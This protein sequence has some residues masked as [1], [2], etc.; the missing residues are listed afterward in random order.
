MLSVDSD[1]SARRNDTTPQT[2]QLII[3]IIII[4]RNEGRPI[5]ASSANVA[6]VTRMFGSSSGDC[7]QN[8]GNYGKRDGFNLEISAMGLKSLYTKYARN[9]TL[10]KNE[11]KIFGIFK[12]RYNKGLYDFD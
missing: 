2:P 1:P 8:D 11:K 9:A 5:R 7:T 6:V 3:A 10:K 4:R 12:A